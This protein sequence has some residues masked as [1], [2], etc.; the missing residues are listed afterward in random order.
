MVILFSCSS[1]ENKTEEPQDQL[2]PVTT[3]GA[4]TAGAVVN[5]I[6]IIPKN[7]TNPT[8]GFPA[9]GLT[10]STAAN[11]GNPN[12]NHYFSLKFTN[13][14]KKEGINYS[15]YI[16]LNDLTNGVNEYIVGQSN[17]EFY[18]DG[19]NNPQI[20]ISQFQNNS[21]TKLFLSS[22]NS[23]V[24]KIL[25][26]DYPNR[27]ISGTFECSNLYNRDNPSEK[28]SVKDGRFDIHIATLNQ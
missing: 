8:S 4:N 27:I 11:F 26:F 14:T 16:H 24:I 5:G 13:L 7:T 18:L 23:G 20:M 12:F 25:K 21:L 6:V 19:P 15:V 9:Y 1:D 10:Y 3:S 2:P 17:G 22:A 28:I